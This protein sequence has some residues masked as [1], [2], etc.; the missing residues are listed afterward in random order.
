M[1]SLKFFYW[2]IILTVVVFFLAV[3]AVDRDFF[4]PV[5][6]RFQGVVGKPV[7]Q[8]VAFQMGKLG[9][10]C[11]SEVSPIS[12]KVS[13]GD[14]NLCLT[15]DT[16]GF[17]GFYFFTVFF[18]TV[19]I[20]F[21]P[22]FSFKR[23]VALLALGWVVLGVYQLLRLTLWMVWVL[24]QNVSFLE[25]PKHAMVQGWFNVGMLTIL[26]MLLLNQLLKPKE[27]YT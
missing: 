16:L 27:K 20:F 23:W 25:M 26:F 10:A 8:A 18:L 22:Y 6:G 17:Y 1:G 7:A 21:R 4:K 11:K 19:F 13:C 15:F 3:M 14:K 24:K 2:R 5:L 9:F 12:S